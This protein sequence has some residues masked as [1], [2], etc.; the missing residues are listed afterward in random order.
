MNQLM[1]EVSV[2]NLSITSIDKSNNTLFRKEKKKTHKRRKSVGFVDAQQEYLKADWDT[3]LELYRTEKRKSQEHL[4][5]SC[6]KHR[7]Y[8]LFGVQKVLKSE[9]EFSNKD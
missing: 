7:I 3:K 9:C 6:F 8:H 2:T 5:C 1:S 4:P